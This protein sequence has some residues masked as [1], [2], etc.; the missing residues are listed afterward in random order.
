M[1]SHFN[2]LSEFGKFR[3][4]INKK[5]LW[6]E[7]EPVPLPL[8]AVELLCVLVAK[9]GEVISKDEIWQEV[10][11]D[12]F[13]E[14]TNLTHYIYLLRKTFKDL[15]MPDLIK[16]VPRRGYR[17]TGS[18]HQIPDQEIVLE[19]HSLTRTTVEISDQTEKVQE[20]DTAAK[21]VVAKRSG[22]RVR[23]ILAAGAVFAVTVAAAVSWKF[24]TDPPDSGAEIRSM[25]VLPI[26]SFGTVSNEDDNEL[27]L[28][29]TDA[30]ITRLGGINNIAVRPTDAILSL[31]N[32]TRSAVELGQELQVD[33]VLQGRMQREDQRLRV[34]LQL[35]SVKTAEQLWS[36]QFDGRSAKLLELQDSI[37]TELMS[38][39][40]S[41]A[42]PRHLAKTVT[43]D[44]DAF[45]AYL[46]GRYFWRKRKEEALRKAIDYFREAVALDPNFAEA[47]VGI[48]DAE[49]ILYD[50]NI[51]L[52]PRIISDA[53]ETL[54]SALLLK[55]DSSDALVTLGTIQM[56]YDW[57]W[58]DAE[59][60]L[61]YA[62]ET[63][64][65]SANA[66]ARYGMLLLKTRKFAESEKALEHAL[67]LDPLSLNGNTAL[68]AAYYC[69]GDLSAAEAQ[70]RK[71]LAI[72]GSFSPAHWFLSRLFWQEGL[73]NKA[74]EEMLTGLELDDN[75]NLAANLKETAGKGDAED[76]I[77]ELLNV[78]QKNPEK[79]NP[80]N[81]AYLSTYVGDKEKAMIWLERS[82]AEHHPWT[83]WA[84][85][86]P[87]FQTLRGDPRFDKIL[88][89]LRLN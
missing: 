3:L 71:T 18:V 26:R 65:N 63:A 36:G 10:W 56:T 8:K 72:N 25:A 32:D 51:E 78:W 12:A 37:S 41:R 80:H 48:A 17:F 61:Q 11:D 43:E 54:Q 57:D 62:T 31:D 77:K 22:S 21:T 16:T 27:R 58:V 47:Y 67:Q 53:K 23:W 38:A 69:G 35:I 1:I 55:P 70:F 73:K 20:T 52:G 19:K 81:I 44:P 46:K 30:L 14:E 59:R 24:R 68:G 42:A 15:G 87:E 2:G 85:S 7:G 83:T 89:G 9:P 34:T 82:L 74:L 88:N 49:M 76:A 40:N 66:W 84:A 33:A 50:Q 39:L 64:P 45:E 5:L 29:L 79:T 60:S 75:E 13:V 4:D 86:A 6:L 28:G